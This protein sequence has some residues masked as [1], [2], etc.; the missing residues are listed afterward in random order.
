MP[1][2]P[3]SDDLQKDA[4]WIEEQKLID[5]HRYGE[6]KIFQGSNFGKKLLTDFNS[7]FI[8]N[9]IFTQ[10]ISAVNREYASLNTYQLVDV[11]H[12]QEHPEEE[13][14]K[15]DELEN[16]EIILFR[17]ASDKTKVEFDI[18]PEELA[19][20]E[21]CLDQETYGSVMHA[22]ESAK[23]KPLL[24]M[25]KV[26]WLYDAHF[27]DDFDEHFRKLTKKDDSLK[28]R[29]KNKIEEMKVEKPKNPV[30]YIADLKGKWKERVG[31]Y[32]MPYAYCE[33]CRQK[34]YE[35]LNQCLDCH[36]KNK[37]SIVFFD[38]FHRS[39]GYEE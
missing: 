10:K 11:V 4:D 24:S 31:N 9:S 15:I 37:N 7:L 22:F 26:F 13:S 35:R 20:L 16:G 19:T 6:G 28:Q 38:V 36:V 2:G 17:L 25:D 33:D 5:S 14:I 34:G 30:E 8:R 27:S 32:R 23:T 12:K 29:L 39:K 18:R 3:Y 21:V 1:Y